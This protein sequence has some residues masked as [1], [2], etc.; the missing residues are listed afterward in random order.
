M[1]S[2]K[3][4]YLPIELDVRE[5]EAKSLLAVHLLK[6]GFHIVI[7][8]Q[9]ELCNQIPNLPPGIFLFKSHN[10]IHQRLMKIAKQYGFF[11]AALEE[12]TLGACSDKNIEKNST[13]ELYDSCDY[14]L[15]CG[16]FEKLFHQK[17][18]KKDNIFIVGNPRAD[19]LKRK[20]LDIFKAKIASIKNRFGRYCLINTNFGIANAFMGD[21]E[22]MKA[23]AID[24]GAIDLKNQQSLRDFEFLLEW[25]T[26]NLISIKEL[27]FELAKE[28]LEINF[29]IRP[30]PAESIELVKNTYKDLTNVYV[31]REG[32]HI[33]WTLGSEILIHT[34]CTT[35]FES[36]L[37]GHNALSLVYEENWYTQSIL[38]NKVNII[39]NSNHEIKKYLKDYFSDLKVPLINETPKTNEL[40]YFVD[41]IGM[42][43][44]VEKIVNIFDDI[45]YK[46]NPLKFSL[47]PTIQRQ[48]YQ[49][50]K[51]TIFAEELEKLIKSF[52]FI[53]G[54]EF[55]EMNFKIQKMADSLF[56]ISPHL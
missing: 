47:G 33:P 38:S 7:G 30:H 14:I 46:S 16:K 32:S 48:E 10:K 44:A 42:N 1:N 5:I 19:I 29:I 37:A 2:S 43:S 17:K 25:E 49:K 36:F 12:E 6:R 24:S 18:T 22:G 15:T 28:N 45:S 8:Q 51:C 41:N 21:V 52:C 53:E 40:E 23:I 39:F 50:I 26:K 55:R 4:V 56:F 27:I 20:Y 3:I 54:D 9:W 31:L 34:S 11:V 35:G 13:N